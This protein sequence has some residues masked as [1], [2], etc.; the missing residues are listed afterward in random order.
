MVGKERSYLIHALRN[1]KEIT[2]LV[3]REQCEQ[4]QTGCGKIMVNVWLEDKAL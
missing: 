4:K 2:F 3:Q 1:G